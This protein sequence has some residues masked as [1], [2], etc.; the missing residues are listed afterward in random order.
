MFKSAT[1]AA[2]IV[3]LIG[4]NLWLALFPGMS[5]AQDDY[6]HQLADLDVAIYSLDVSPNGRI[7]AVGTDSG[8]L[9]LWDI[10]AET[11]IDEPVQAHKGW[12]NAVAFS[13]TGRL[14]ASSSCGAPLSIDG[15]CP[16]GGEIAFWNIDEMGTIQA[17]G[18]LLRG[19][20]DNVA[21]LAFSPDGSLLASAGVFPGNSLFVWDLGVES[22]DPI[23]QIDVPGVIDVDFSP[24]GNVLAAT[25]CPDYDGV[26]CSQGSIRLFDAVTGELLTDPLVMNEELPL[27]VAFSPNGRTIAAADTVSTIFVWNWRTGERPFAPIIATPVTMP[28]GPIYDLSFNSTGGFLASASGDGVVRAWNL[29]LIENGRPIEHILG[30][31][32]RGEASGV[33]F[34]GEGNTLVSSGAD[35]SVWIWASDRPEQTGAAIEANVTILRGH[36]DSV[37]RV[38]FVDGGQSLVSGGYDDQLIFWDT[39]TGLRSSSFFIGSRGITAVAVSPDERFVAVAGADNPIILWDVDQGQKIAELSDGHLAEATVWSVAFSPDGQLLASSDDTG[40]IRLWDVSETASGVVQMLTPPLQHDQA[41]WSVT[42][43]PD[44]EIL[45]SASSDTT[46]RLWDVANHQIL[47]VPLEGHLDIVWGV[48]FSPDGQQFASTSADGTVR[49]WDITSE[50]GEERILIKAGPGDVYSAAFSPDGKTLATAGADFTVKLWD[51]VTGE[52]IAE[53][54]T[55]HTNQVYYVTFDPDGETLASC[56]ANGLIALW[57]MPD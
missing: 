38:S 54:L 50:G 26:F 43:S 48:T 9:Y 25:S 31:H 17:S 11:T 42:F 32:D 55:E 34:S 6:P 45:A 8:Q 40:L 3:I 13:P 28:V 47:G 44:G 39:S 23:L 15:T 56:D 21:G 16:S 46:I 49:L 30:G 12:V 1:R 33:A 53:P 29:D 4:L 27:S 20:I 5:H 36:T 2:F 35:G 7:A 57:A 37:N 18:T 14:L 52:T 24:D 10:E 22:P 41:V 19:H 51:S